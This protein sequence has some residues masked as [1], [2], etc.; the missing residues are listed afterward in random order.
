MP[1]LVTGAGGGGGGGGESNS[2]SPTSKP[3]TTLWPEDVGSTTSDDTVIEGMPGVAGA[4]K[5]N[6]TEQ[7]LECDGAAVSTIA[8]TTTGPYG[9]YLE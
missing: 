4:A 6:T 9:L 2:Q 5:S 1:P 3:A 7:L 8:D